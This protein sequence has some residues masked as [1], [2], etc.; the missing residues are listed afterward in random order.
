MRPP[1]R[2][3]PFLLLG[4]VALAVPAL[5]APTLVRT[6]PNKSTLIL[7]ENRTRPIVSIQAWIKSGSRDESRSERG[8]AVVLQQI[9]LRASKKRV[10]DDIRK[11]IALYSATFGSDVGYDYSLFE[12]TLPARYFKAG[13]DLL[14]EMVTQPRLDTRDIQQSISI[15]RDQ[16][17]YVL[18]Q[19]E[20]ATSNPVRDALWS[21][22]PM[23]SP[24]T[25][26]ELELAAVTMPLAVRYYKTHYVSENLMLVVVGDVDPAEAPAIMEKA[27]ASMPEG[28]APKH[29]KMEIKGAPSTKIS[30]VDQPPDAGSAFA[31][32]FRAP[33]W[34]TAD[35][36]ALDVL[37]AALIDS[38]HSRIL[39]RP[40][41]GSDAFVNITAQRSFDVDGGTI[42]LS[43][44]ID[45]SRAKD[46][47]AALIATLAQ[48]RTAPI[49][50]GEMDDAVNAVVSREG[51]HASDMT[52]LA[53]ATGLAYLR[54]KPGAD[55][56]YYDRLR[57]VRPEDLIG[58]AA[59]Y[60][61]L[62][63]AAVVEMMP[64]AMA[65]S[66]GAKS[67]FEGRIKEKLGIN[68]AAYGKG[69][70]VTQSSPQDR[71]KRIDAPLAKIPSTAPDL[72][73]ARVEKTTLAGGLRVL[74]SQDRST[75]TVTVAVYLG[76]GTRYENETNN[77]VTSLLRESI[78]TST[79]PKADHGAAYRHSL[80][81]LGP[82]QSYQDK[83]MWG[84]SLSVPSS[85]WKEAVTR[86]GM[87]LAH[88]EIDSVTVDA[89]R[90]FVLE[91]LHK[92]SDND[93]VQR[94]WSIFPVKYQVSGY[95]LPALGTPYN[96]M[97]MPYGTIIDWYK[98]FVV[99][100]N[101]VVSV[102]GDI[103]PSEVGP[104]VDHA[105]AEV[106]SKPFQPPAVKKEPPFEGFREK[107]DLGA[108]TDCTVN[109]A[110]NG[111]PARSRDIPTFYVI[112]SLLSGP[113]S[114]FEQYINS[115]AA[116]F[117]G[118]SSTVSLSIDESP[119]IASVVIVG[120]VVEEDGVKLLFRQ[121]KKVAFYEMT[122]EEADTLRYAKVH[123]AGTQLNLL[124]TN[125]TRA[126]Q[127]GR[128]EVYGLGMEYP[129][130]LPV[131][132]DAVTAEDV[133]AAGLV[134]FEKDP[135]NR[136]PYTITETRP[137]GW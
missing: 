88:P 39:T 132:I 106:S 64:R 109:L 76:G 75:P 86:L 18:R 130:T 79:D 90:L 30:F 52:G 80:P 120:P 62:D 11:D 21:G 65:D 51:F 22:T 59:Q 37:L 41:E 13:A 42:S 35:A 129:L 84:F 134:Y 78:L 85:E 31:I 107:W 6:L 137:G 121:F 103:T 127:W 57:S 10:A 131:K 74:T 66:L 73:R 116:L 14:G 77:G 23:G 4:L 93:Q 27:F 108:G 102:F 115:N 119:L 81:D 98:T 122:S 32:G 91:A 82:F 16:A 118:S 89:T 2:L 135:F 12:I 56:V 69:P 55:E 46:A 110:F 126:F 9:M 96:L 26:P 112:N 38:P 128:A 83:D 136:Q 117:R 72:G 71:Q 34:G 25:V 123:A 49:S 105:F 133:Q 87:M 95:R 63:H 29:P 7:R 24:S 45:P 44:R 125:T 61:D 1:L 3:I 54:G 58:V 70:K 28:K 68:Q 33:Q 111:P 5:A 36:V 60:L 17:K 113:R 94:A 20:L 48:A 19:A 53:H 50:Q 43:G 97:A 114:W 8:A 100:G 104:A 92:W 47:E 40:V 67:G 124:G 15:A 99:R 101:L